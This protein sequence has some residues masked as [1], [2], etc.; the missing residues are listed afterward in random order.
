MLGN[1]QFG[2]MKW[3]VLGWFWFCLLQS[4][5]EKAIATGFLD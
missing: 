4:L 3:G 2:R 5:D 1:G